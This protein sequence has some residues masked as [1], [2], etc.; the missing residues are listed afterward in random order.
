MVFNIVS[1]EPHVK[2]G[3]ATSRDL[4][5]QISFLFY[6]LLFPFFIVNESLIKK[7]LNYVANILLN[8]SQRPQY[9]GQYII[10]L[11]KVLEFSQ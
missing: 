7:L 5:F 11:C 8:P 4:S 6:L 10:V 2:G 1:M 9:V 3:E